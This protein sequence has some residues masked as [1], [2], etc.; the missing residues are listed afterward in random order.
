MANDLNLGEL[1]RL[2]GEA[3]PGPWW[4]DNAGDGELMSGD[5]ERF[6]TCQTVGIGCVR[7][8]D[9]EFLTALRN[10]FPALLALARRAA[11]AEAEVARLR[12]L[13]N[14]GNVPVH[15]L[16]L[17]DQLRAELEKRRSPEAMLEY[18]QSI[19]GFDTPCSVC[20]GT[21][22]QSYSST[23]TWQGGFGGQAFTTDVCDHCW[24]SGDEHRHGANLRELR[25]EVERLKASAS[26]CPDCG[27]ELEILC[28]GACVTRALRETMGEP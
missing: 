17:N 15:L 1:E 12:D 22:V 24:G 5:P 20:H 4:R 27:G 2:H 26:T 25:A 6:E 8:E 16:E 21:G 9:D 23:A 28:S 18:L 13:L 11:K 7:V 10:A 19:R 14:T 3:T